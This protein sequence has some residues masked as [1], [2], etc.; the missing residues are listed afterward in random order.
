[1]G[2]TAAFGGGAAL[3]V[4]GQSDHNSMVLSNNRFIANKAT[5]GGGGFNVGYTC[6][7]SYQYP[8]HNSIDICNSSFVQN[9]ALFGGGMSIFFASIGHFQKHPNNS[10]KCEECYIKNNTARGGAAVNVSP[11]M[12]KHFGIQNILIIDFVNSSFDNNLVTFD[13]NNGGAAEGNGA[14]FASNVD[15]GFYGSISFTGNNGTALYLDSSTTFFLY[16]VSVHFCN[17]SGYQGGAILLL[18]TSQIFLDYHGY[19]YFFNN[20]ATTFGGAICDLT[21]GQHIY[22]YLKTCFLEVYSKKVTKFLYLDFSNNSAEIGNAICT[23]SL[24]SCDLSCEHVI[25][26]PFVNNQTHFFD[27]TCH[28]NYTFKDTKDDIKHV[29]TSPFNV[30]IG[31]R[32]SS[33]VAVFPG[34]PALLDIVQYDEC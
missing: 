15:L 20:Y 29:A 33:I 25:G 14:F 1:M 32:S 11:D 9:D 3:F 27:T 2:N 26:H 22:A 23:T 30:T 21:S 7:Y 17:N 12:F 28:G 10:L 6:H 13:T 34:I 31:R 4:S 19:F 16:N 24:A 5:A 8:M 18:G